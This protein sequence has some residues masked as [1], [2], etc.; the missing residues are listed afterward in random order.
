[1]TPVG[2]D[3]LQDVRAMFQRDASEDELREALERYALVAGAED[4]VFLLLE[5]L[6]PL[7]PAMRLRYA[8]F[9]DP[10]DSRPAGSIWKDPEAALR[11]YRR[12][13]AD[14]APEAQQA[15]ETLR[16]WAEEEADRGNVQAIDLL[17][18]W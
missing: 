8:A 10:T 18:L 16:A 14:G 7:D 11:E 9:F 5:G 17:E 1:M 6:A 3:A 2:R 4:A 15:I 12:A 13:Q